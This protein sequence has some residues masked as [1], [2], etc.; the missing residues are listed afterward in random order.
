MKR[1]V[2]KEQFF[3]TEENVNECLKHLDLNS[4][5]KIVE[6]SAGNGSFSNKIENCIAYDI[7]PLAENIIKQDFLELKFEKNNERILVIGNPP[8]GRQSSMAVKFINKA[9]E[10]ADTIAFILP[11]SFKKETLINRLNKHLFLTEVYDLV[12][13]NFFFEDNT[14]TI[15]CAFFVFEKRGEVRQK[16]EKLTTEDFTFVKQSEADN[17]IRRVGFYAGR[18]ESKDATVS[19]H[20]FVKWNTPQVKE[21]FS[22]LKFEHNNT[23]G[24]RSLSKQEMI[25]AY[26]KYKETL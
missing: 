14:Y 10:F 3:T 15:P 25:S 13:Y 19:S 6:P 17:S 22:K 8:F 12:N 2:A 7:E 16:I 4:Y 11:L 9:A 20:Y 1:E 5:D 18:I 23:V 26:L 21:I 24:S